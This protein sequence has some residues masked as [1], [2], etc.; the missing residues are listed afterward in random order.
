[1]KILITGSGGL[2][3]SELCDYFDKLNYKIIGIDNDQRKLFFGK[4]GSVNW[5][6]KELKQN[7]KNYTHY[8]IDIRD[9][10]KLFKIFK[11]FKPDAIAHCAAQPS[12]DLATKIIFDGFNL[13]S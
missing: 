12:H 5:K 7:L 1:M 9:K 10:K 4:N 2:I 3:G 6:I 13:I 11:K 8:N